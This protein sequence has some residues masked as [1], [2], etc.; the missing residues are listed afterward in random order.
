[1]P[2]NNGV[3]RSGLDHLALNQLL[4]PVDIPN[5]NLSLDLFAANEPFNLAY[6]TYSPKTPAVVVPSPAAVPIE[7]FGVQFTGNPVDPANFPREFYLGSPI[8]GF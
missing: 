1:M 4:M 2:L 7:E 5:P 8:G 6:H 3:Y